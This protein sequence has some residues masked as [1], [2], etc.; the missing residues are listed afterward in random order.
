SPA[1][2]P[3]STTTPPPAPAPTPVALASLPPSSP[4]DKIVTAYSTNPRISARPPREQEVYLA[5]VLAVQVKVRMLTKESDPIAFFVPYGFNAVDFYIGPIEVNPDFGKPEDLDE[6]VTVGELTIGGV[7]ERLTP[8]DQISVVV[9][10]RH[11][12]WVEMAADHL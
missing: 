3:T 4:G 5:E 12:S 10:W 1:S 8:G 9:P 2:Q 11:A 7:D 6:V